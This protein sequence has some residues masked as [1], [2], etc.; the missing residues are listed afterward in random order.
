MKFKVDNENTGTL[1]VQIG[2]TKD[3]IK[4]TGL[5][6]DKMYRW[7]PMNI[8][9]KY[10][11]QE[12]RARLYLYPVTNPPENPDYDYEARKRTKPAGIVVEKIG[13]DMVCLNVMTDNIEL[14]IQA[15]ELGLP[16]MISARKTLKEIKEGIKDLLEMLDDVK[17]TLEDRLSKEIN[18]KEF[19]KLPL[20]EQDSVLYSYASEEEIEQ[21]VLFGKLYTMLNLMR[22]IA[23]A[24]EEA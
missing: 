2:N 16:H 21:M 24:R 12:P 9:Y 8:S 6:L 10:R 23:E 5:K 17:D 14:A 13:P 19:R 1:E 4:F 3:N 11:Y 7:Y 18:L 20:Q 15:D 22:K